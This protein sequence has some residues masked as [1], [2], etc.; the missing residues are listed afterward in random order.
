MIDNLLAPA[1]VS[2]TNP[3]AQR[4]QLVFPFIKQDVPIEPK[5]TIIVL[6][7]TAAEVYGFLSQQDAGFTV[8]VEPI[9]QSGSV[10]PKPPAPQKTETKTTIAKATGSIS[11]QEFDNGEM[12][13]SGSDTEITISGKLSYCE[14]SVGKAFGFK[15]VNNFITLKLTV[16]NIGEDATLTTQKES[17]KVNSYKKSA[18]DGDNYIYLVLDGNG[19]SF[20][21]KVKAT[22]DAEEKVITVTNNATC[23]PKP[24]AAKPTEAS[25][26]FTLVEALQKGGDIKLTSNIESVTSPFK[27]TQNTVLDLDGKKIEDLVYCKNGVALFQIS[28]NAT[29]RVKGNGT[30]NCMV[31]YTFDVGSVNNSYGGTLIIEDGNYTGDTTVVQVEKGK[32]EILGGEFKVADEGSE[33]AANYMLN[34]IDEH[35]DGATIEVSGGKFHKFNPQ[36][37]KDPGSPSYLKAGYKS[38]M[39]GDN[40]WTVTQEG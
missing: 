17:G 31:G 21:I 39:S 5:Q 27:V 26:Y 14:D 15:G 3:T 37:A 24:E 32:A 4:K 40:L 1:K 9:E 19:A 22:A 2:I 30:I 35:L 20:T 38:T 34:R 28:N 11:G 23:D 16:D 25:S 33:W 6:A 7:R 10:P 36:V 18:F 8:T 29:L 13:V 12:T